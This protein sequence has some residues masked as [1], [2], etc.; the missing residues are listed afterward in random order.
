MLSLFLINIFEKFFKKCLYD[1]LAKN[2]Y[3]FQSGKLIFDVLVKAD[4]Y[5]GDNLDKNDKVMGIFLDLKKVFDS[6]NHSY[7]I[8]NLEYAGVRGKARNLF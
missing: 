2:Q 1:F 8:K 7:L 6:V 5:I 4:N 3:G